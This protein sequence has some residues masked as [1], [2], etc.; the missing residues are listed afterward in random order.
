M[1]NL[2]TALALGKLDA[3]EQA[4][5]LRSRQLRPLDLVEAAI[6]RVETLD[7]H[8]SALTYL[9][10]DLARDRASEP[11]TRSFAGVPYLVKDS[12]DYPGMP[13]FAGS[14]SRTGALRT[15]ALPFVQRLDAEGLVPIGKSAMPE[16]G[17]LP[18]TE[19]LRGPVTHNPWARDRSPGGSSGGAAAA[20]AAGIVPLAHA[21]D[22]AGSIRIPAA[23]CGVVGLKPG[24]AVNV[25]AR[26]R[27]LLDDMLVSDALL[28]RSV[29]DAAWAFSATRASPGSV[30]TSASS[31]RLRIGISMNTLSGDAPTSEVADAVKRAGELCASLGHIVEETPMPIDG[32]AAAEAI[33]VLWAH[34]GAD[35]VDTVR[36]AG[37]DPELVLEPWTLGL[38]RM[39]ERLPLDVLERAFRQVSALPRQLA[40]HFRVYDVVL[41]P[42]L[43]HGT[44]L[45]GEMSPTKP[46][47]ELLTRMFDWLGY[48]PL[49]NLAGTP[50][51]SLPL[52]HSDDGLPIGVMFSSDRGGEDTLLALA[53]E[54]E[55]ASPWKERWPPYSAAREHDRE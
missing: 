8:L 11:S 18:T 14:R 42:T 40:R 37:L 7:P 19:P 17:L 31:R 52:A 46:F 23:C 33:R 43:R 4:S 12:L 21:S 48:T 22:G 32:P 5:L 29:R 2:D 20:V 1:M 45:I 6:L 3:H 41:T 38:G 47:D 10:F 51:I 39:A 54:L 34:V 9:A 27:N 16:F 49:Q 15:T 50:A 36:T 28:A 30:V 26:G 44:P 25:R 53:Y 24:R 13:S 55:A 35:C